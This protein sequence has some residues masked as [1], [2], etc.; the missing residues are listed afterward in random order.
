MMTALNSP[1]KGFALSP[2]GLRYDYVALMM[3]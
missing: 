3:S 1:E 2:K